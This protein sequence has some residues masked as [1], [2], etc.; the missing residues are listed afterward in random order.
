MEAIAPQMTLRGR[1]MGE[2]LERV[3]VSD[4]SQT[5][6]MRGGGADIAGPRFLSRSLLDLSII[7]V[8]YC[9]VPKFYP[10]AVTVPGFFIESRGQL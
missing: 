2:L 9:C 6:L 10:R 1:R 7:V 5:H 8:S 3:A 4:A